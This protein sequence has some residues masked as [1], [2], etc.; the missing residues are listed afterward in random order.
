MRNAMLLALGLLSAAPA[1]GH[2]EPAIRDNVS[3][4]VEATR[5][6][7]NDWATATVGVTEEAGDPA[8][9]AGNVNRRIAGAFAV[10]KKAKGVTPTSGA[11]QT[12]P[13][14]EQDRIARWRASQD[15]IL[16]SGDVGVLS[17][18]IG[19]LQG[20]GIELRG[21]Q[22]SV[23]D[24]TRRRIENELISEGLAAFKARAELIAKGLGRQS[25]RLVNLGVGQTDGGGPLPYAQAE[26]AMRSVDVAPPQLEGGTSE[27]RIDIDATIA[28]E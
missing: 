18:L 21:I 27:V 13:V 15:L 9:L 6:V 7:G 14:Y 23:S 10:A 25:Y 3:F 12:Y 28:L 5:D 26:V 16:E 11:Y 4:R 22:F 2:D 24:A 20:Q 8:T 1:L 19:T 17:D